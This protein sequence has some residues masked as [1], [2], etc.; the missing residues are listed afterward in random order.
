MYFDMGEGGVKKPG[1]KSFF[2]ESYLICSEMNRLFCTCAKGHDALLGIFK[3]TQIIFFILKVRKF[4]NKCMKSSHC[5]KYK[6]K[7]GKSLL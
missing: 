4:Q 5:P 1:K 7:N 3:R 2:M 6:Q